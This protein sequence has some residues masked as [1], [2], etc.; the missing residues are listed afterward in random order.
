[1]RASTHVGRDIQMEA[2]TDTSLHPR[3]IIVGIIIQVDFVLDRS[4]G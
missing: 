1:M 4:L 3:L 2:Y